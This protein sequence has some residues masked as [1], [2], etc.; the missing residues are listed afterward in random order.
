[1]EW[2]HS[3]TEEVRR[4]SM[5]ARK[6]TGNRRITQ[7]PQKVWIHGW[8]YRMVLVTGSSWQ[9]SWQC[10][11]D[12]DSKKKKKKF[13]DKSEKTPRTSVW[14]S[15]PKSHSTIGHGKQHAPLWEYVCDLYEATGK[16]TVVI[17]FAMI[18]VI[19][20]NQI[21]LWTP[22]P[23]YLYALLVAFPHTY[24]MLRI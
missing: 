3:P 15:L 18:T 6:R 2:A 14:V 8:L 5:R 4:T 23:W 1:M 12:A 13:T 21:N 17:V 22:A 16:L 10:N 24:V 11:H 9:Q 20:W 19:N 7:S